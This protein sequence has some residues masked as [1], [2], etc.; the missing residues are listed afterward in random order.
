MV[1]FVEGGE[2]LCCDNCFRSFHLECVDLKE[3]P[4]GD[5][6]CRFCRDLQEDK[7]EECPTCQEGLEEVEQYEKVTCSKCL[8]KY[9][10]KV[11]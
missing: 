8:R 3:G 9:V 7:V 4:E 5:W 1:N 6:I 11:F 2:I 10:M